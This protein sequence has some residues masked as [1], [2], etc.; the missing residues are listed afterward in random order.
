[1][2]AIGCGA[3]L[4]CVAACRCHNTA[5]TAVSPPFGGSLTVWA[6]AEATLSEGVLI[7]KS[8][9]ID[10]MAD[11]GVPLDIVE[12]IARRRRGEQMELSEEERRQR[13]TFVRRFLTSEIDRL[14]A[15]GDPWGSVERGCR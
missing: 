12:R 1:M 10:R 14:L 11:R 6:R 15:P 8:E 7:T 5:R 3:P 4:R 9:A 2:V 13:S